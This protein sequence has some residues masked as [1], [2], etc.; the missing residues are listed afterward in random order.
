MKEFNDSNFFFFLTFSSLPLRY[1]KKCGYT[2][3][4][5]IH[6]IVKEKPHFVHRNDENSKSLRNIKGAVFQNPTKL[7]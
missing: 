4:F 7:K 1:C 3:F 5:K 2:F 6:E